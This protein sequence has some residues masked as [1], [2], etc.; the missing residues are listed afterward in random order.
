MNCFKSENSQ[1]PVKSNSSSSNSNSRK[2]NNSSNTSNESDDH[3]TH[4]RI[5]SLT[6][7]ISH[8]MKFRYKNQTESLLDD[9][10]SNI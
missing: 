7:T 8:I 9:D 10:K 3:T 4:S 6:N 5:I 1:T 2:N